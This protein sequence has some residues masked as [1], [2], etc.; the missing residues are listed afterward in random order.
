[1]ETV[2]SFVK[3]A[4]TFIA[5]VQVCEGAAIVANINKR[6]DYPRASNAVAITGLRIW[7]YILW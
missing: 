2:N 6:G 1:M 7:E 4:P 5:K 3:T